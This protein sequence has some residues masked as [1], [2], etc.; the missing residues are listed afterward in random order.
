MWLSSQIHCVNNEQRTKERN[1]YVKEQCL[2]V[3]IED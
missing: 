2:P 1:K 3:E